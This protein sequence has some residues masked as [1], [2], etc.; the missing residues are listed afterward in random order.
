MKLLK[1]IKTYI[2]FILVCL[3]F[4]FLY[5]QRWSVGKVRSKPK[6]DGFSEV[7]PE[8]LKTD[9]IKIPLPV[10]SNDVQSVVT[11]TTTTVEDITVTTE[12]DPSMNTPV[13][14]KRAQDLLSKYK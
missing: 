4:L 12:K 1:A 10:P 5:L 6:V 9:E 3:G 2:W 7:T 8:E 13:P 11:L 14:V